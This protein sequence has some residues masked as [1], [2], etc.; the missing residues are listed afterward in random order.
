MK[1]VFYHETK[2]GKLGIA[3]EYGFITNV[4]FMNMKQPLY[5]K[6]Y[7]TE[8]IKEGFSQIEEYL[9]GE[10]KEFDLPLNPSGTSFQQQVWCEILKIPYGDT[11]TYKDISTD[12]GNDNSARAVGSAT[13][14]NPIP[15]IIPCHR[16]VGANNKTSGY[17]GGV[18]LKN[19]LLNIEQMYK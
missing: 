7:E 2:I 9:K 4:Y 19:T 3:E 12:L 5:A 16:V 18:E 6:L 14:K 8:V 13:G 10:R 17:I 11:V 15:I 1:R